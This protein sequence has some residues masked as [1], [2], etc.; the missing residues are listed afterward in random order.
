MRVPLHQ[1]EYDLYTHLA[2]NIGPGAF[3]GSTLVK[4]LNAG[5]YLSACQQILAFEHG[6]NRLCLNGGWVFVALFA[7]GFENRRSEVQ[8]VKSHGV[9]PLPGTGESACPGAW[10]RWASLGR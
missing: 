10:Q 9:V 2:Y 7:N 5:D 4:K 1:A 6:G 3:C 8:I